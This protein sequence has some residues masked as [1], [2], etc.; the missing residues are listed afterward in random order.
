[1][2]FTAHQ[3]LFGWYTKKNEMRGHLSRMGREEVR[4]RFLWGKREGKNHLEDLG[5][6]G[7]IKNKNGLQNIGR[8]W[9]GLDKIV[10]AQNRES[11]QAV[12]STVM[13]L[14]VP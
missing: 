8:F 1:V 10:V 9:G 12:V 7:S 11:W 14:R 6:D 13:N 3:I 5:V 2:I 4:T